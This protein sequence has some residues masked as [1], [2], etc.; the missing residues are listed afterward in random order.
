MAQ[1]IGYANKYIV[2]SG[3]RWLR[4]DLS[5]RPHYRGGPS[6]KQRRVLKPRLAA[7]VA[8]AATRAR[9][10]FEVG[11]D[12]RFMTGYW[13]DRI[14]L[15]VHVGVV[16][17]FGHPV[18]RSMLNTMDTIHA[19]KWIWLASRSARRVIGRWRAAIR[20]GRRYSF[21]HSLIRDRPAVN[22]IWSKNGRRQAQC[23]WLR[24]GHV[25]IPNC[26]RGRLGPRL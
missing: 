2:A 24:C 9:P 18:R 13:G 12:P 14:A 5:I 1:C 23:Y 17:D 4:F 6:G 21:Y 22:L 15:S 16:R 10:S 26:G 3:T 11:E 20:R 25:L 8:I 19:L 7:T